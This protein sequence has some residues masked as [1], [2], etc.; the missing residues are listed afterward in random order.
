MEKKTAIFIFLFGAAAGG[1]AGRTLM[2]DANATVPSSFIH[3]MCVRQ[4]LPDGGYTVEAYGS[5]KLPDGGSI[6]VG[7]IKNRIEVSPKL[8]DALER[9]VNREWRKVQFGADAGE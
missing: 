3:A 9:E 6:D 5:L 1:I 7:G 8:V 4:D 2:L